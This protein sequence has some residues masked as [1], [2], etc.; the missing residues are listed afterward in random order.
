MT[1]I[2]NANRLTLCSIMCLWDTLHTS[3][4]EKQCNYK[5]CKWTHTHTHLRYTTALTM[6]E[7]TLH[8]YFLPL[9]GV[10][11]IFSAQK[12]ADK[13]ST[14]AAHFHSLPNM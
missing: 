7:I 1:S 12:W 14:S 5:S 6:K 4:K 13:I 10:G 9:L 3:G 8:F 11:P 2:Q